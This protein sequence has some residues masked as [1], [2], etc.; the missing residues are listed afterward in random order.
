M[1]AELELW[2]QLPVAD[3]RH[4]IEVARR[5][6]SMGQWTREEMAGALLHDIG[7]LEVGPRHG[8]CVSSPLWSVRAP[9]A[10]GSITITSE[11]APTC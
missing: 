9:S 8:G 5:F 7:K 1:P 4:S 11:S 6:Q 3:R 10:S 2:R